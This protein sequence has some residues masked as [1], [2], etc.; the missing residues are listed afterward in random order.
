MIA[1][2]AALLSGLPSCGEQPGDYSAETGR[3]QT[4]S[5][6]RLTQAEGPERSWSLQ[7]D[8][9]VY[10]E[11]DSLVTLSGVFI[12]FFK[13]NRPESTV[14]SDSGRAGLTTGTTV[15]WGSVVAE[16][17]RGR[18]LETQLLLWDDSLG[19]FYTDCLAVFT[20]PEDDGVTV[21]RGRGVTLNTG[22]GTLGDVLVHQSFSAVYSGEVDDFD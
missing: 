16:N 15:L 1:G 8:T 9:A 4:V 17:T 5:G 3:I 18:R 11:D 2:A 13:D 22:L 6:F 14:R 20:V 21:L 19:V 12:T 10:L 7:G